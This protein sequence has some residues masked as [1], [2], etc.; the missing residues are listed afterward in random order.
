M[1]VRLHLPL[2]LAAVQDALFRSVFRSPCR[3]DLK[4]RV[5]ELA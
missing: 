2:L 5:L 4:T 3:L 1:T